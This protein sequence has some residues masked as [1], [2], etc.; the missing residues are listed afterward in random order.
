MP[1]AIRSK[2]MTLTDLNGRPV[3]IGQK[4]KT[5]MG[6]SVTLLGGTSPTYAGGDGR[7]YVQRKNGFKEE[8][9]P[10]TCNLTWQR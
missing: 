7:I 10:S 9:K 6:E 4:I 5:V 3:S 8:L 1:M 2:D